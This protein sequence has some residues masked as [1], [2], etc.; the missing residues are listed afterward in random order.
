MRLTALFAY[1]APFLAAL[2]SSTPIYC[3][4]VSWHILW[5]KFNRK[6][7]NNPWP[8]HQVFDNET[9][10]SSQSTRD[11]ILKGDLP[12]EACCSYGRC[13]G[14]VVVAMAWRE[15]SEQESSWHQLLDDK[16]NTARQTGKQLW[17]G[18]M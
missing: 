3:P 11:L 9:N 5:T 13:Q 6:Q 1:A 18:S 12:P 17:N 16:L 2:V 14:D 15:R 10:S 8:Y 7:R 4:D